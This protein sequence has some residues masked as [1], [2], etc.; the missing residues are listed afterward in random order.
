MQTL[1]NELGQLRYTITPKAVKELEAA[2][3]VMSQ[4]IADELCFWYDYDELGRTIAKKTP[5]KGVEYI[6][7]DKRNRPVFTQDANQRAKSPDEWVTAL[8]DDLNR[9]VLSGIYKSDNTRDQL[10]TT[11]STPNTLITV[12]ATNGGSI[13]LWGS[14]L[15]A[16]EINTTTVFTQLSFSYY[17]NYTYTGA[18][19]YNSTHIQNLVYKNAAATDDIETAALTSRI[20]GVVTG[21]KT[22]VMD[23]AATP[24][25]LTSSVFF[26]E[27]GRGIQVQSDNIKTG[28]D[29]ISTQFHFDGRA[30]SKSETHN[31][32]GTVYTNFNILTKYKFDKI[33]RV[34]GIGKKINNAARTYITSPN[35]STAQEDDDAGY[36]ITAAYKYNELGRMIK[37]TLSPTGGTGGTA[38][39]TIDYTYSMRGWLTGINKD[40]A[41]G[42]YTSNQWDHFFGM[43]IGYDNRD[44]KFTN[45][46]LNGQITGVQWKSQ[47]DNTPRKFDYVYDNA[48]RLL[49]AN[50]A[51]K[52]SSSEAWNVGKMDFSTKNV[53][54]DENG[55]L[56]GMT[57]M[58]VLP[59]AAAPVTLDNLVYTYTTLT[60]K[61]IRVDDNGTAGAANGKQTD[62]KDGAN[63]AGTADYSYDAN[64][65]LILDNNKRVTVV[66]YNYLDK[67]ELITIAPP[68]ASTGGGTIKYV[69]SAGGSKMQKIVT[70]NA[71]AANGNQVRIITT[72]YIGAFVYEAI[73]IGGTAQP[74]ALQMI[75]HEEGRIRV[76]TPYINAADPANYIGGGIV[77]P[78]SKQGVF[79]YFITDNLGNV[80]TTITEEINKAS[81]VCTM[82]D[83]N[84]T[85]KQNEEALFGNVTGNEVVATR[86]IKP[87]AWT[88]NTTAKVSKLQSPDGTATKTGPNVLLRVMAGDLINATTDYYYLQNPGSS[89]SPATGLSAM[90]QSLVSAFTGGKATGLVK[91]QATVIILLKGQNSE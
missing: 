27:E 18:K 12:S 49:T 14:P 46:Q 58:G 79:D 68:P 91:D 66:T 70:E 81:S 1:Y 47:G 29:I 32:T 3:W 15:T 89:A 22:L 71:S 4:A 53:S 17:D 9:P 55:N 77:L 63:A 50:Y 35:I 52:G 65:N 23:G 42:E 36:K 78:G 5:G 40:Y 90:L 19:T 33:G 34:V 25:Y 69:Y 6:V 72:S 75:G 67:P 45:A 84:A 20:N 13:K 80:R 88:A 8:Y 48:D 37:K 2:G 24:K 26:D 31:G 16:T 28:V 62:F 76:I 57:Q 38:L 74:E 51:Q 85:V 11:A 82:E 61:L 41:L 56:L 60:N 87:V 54:Y 83:A 44:G 73:T 39:E 30:L 59:G 43:Y 64:G 7:Y 10:Q 21:G 86:F